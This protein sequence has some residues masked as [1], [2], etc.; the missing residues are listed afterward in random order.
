MKSM[1][2][3]RPIG[4]IGRKRCAG[5][6]A[7][8]ARVAAVVLAGILPL[9]GATGTLAADND[10]V[11]TAAFPIGE[12]LVYTIHWGILSVG[13]TKITTSWVDNDGRRLLLI[14][15][16]TESNSVLE[17]VYPV[18]SVIE[19]LVEPDTFLPV[20]FSQNSTE[21]RHRTYEV[22]RFD[23]DKR[24]AYWESK[25]TGKRRIYAIEDD[26]R[27]L[28]TFLY[29]VRASRFEPGD[30]R[31]YRVM[32]D[33]RLYDLLVKAEAEESIKLK[34][35]GKVKSVRIEPRAAFKGL[36]VRKGRMTI[37]V[38]RDPRSL[39]TQLEVEVP[40]ASVRAKLD[41]VRG[42]G[43]DDWVN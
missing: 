33:G 5:G 25:L 39:C 30:E 11:V 28:V 7:C 40:I 20:L 19:A 24:I 14:R 16:V 32:A 9:C 36:F 2:D 27:D 10:Q 23:F 3:R 1:H 35:Y 38:S 26:T 37:W 6:S 29:F 41:R 43:N 34:R 12:E 21:G 13:T 17:K 42:P 31:E 22:T 4:P 8:R 18:K 15:Y